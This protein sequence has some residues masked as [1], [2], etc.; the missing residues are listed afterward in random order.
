MQER[1]K[2]LN[3]HLC[4]DEIWVLTT[5]PFILLS[6]RFFLSGLQGPELVLFCLLKVASL[7]W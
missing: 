6:L 7:F 5:F 4:C 2:A 1:F 3:L